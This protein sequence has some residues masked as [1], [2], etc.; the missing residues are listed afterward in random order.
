MKINIKNIGVKSIC[1]TLFISLFLSCNNSGESAE[2]ENR[3]NSVLMDVGR[4]TENVFYS[5]IDLI[6]DTL[7]FRVTAETKK[8]D[9]AG[10]FGGLG[11]K[12][13]KASERLEEVAKKSE[14]EGAKERP[15][16]L[17]IREAV[18]TAK[19]TLETLKGHLE[20]LK[21]IGDSNKVGCAATGDTQGVS[22]N[23]GE[24][25]NI[26]K[27]L[28]EIVELAKVSG[29]I[30]ALDAGNTTLKVGG[31]GVDNKDGAKILST[32]GGATQN[33]PAKAAAILASVSGGEMLAS[34]VGSQEGDADTGVSGNA[35]GST[36]ALKFAKGG[37]AGNLANSENAKAAAVAGGIALRSLV[38]EGKLAAGGNNGSTGEQK[39]SEGV[40]ITAANKLL[41]AVEDIIK[42]TVKNVLGKAK[43]EIDKARGPKSAVLE[44]SK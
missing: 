15:I 4:S 22:A 17:A 13:G 23:P 14:V 8:S 16:A 38:K 32:N 39:E 28:R 27:A 11:E 25:K 43:G 10:Y 34:I 7:G 1:A 2:A 42:K 41:V 9:V 18:D 3:L 44:P 21:S 36:S 5:F 24:L 6:S 33:A 30:K 19:K 20:S 26:F 40:G 35:D 31:V 29:V 37:T 12:L